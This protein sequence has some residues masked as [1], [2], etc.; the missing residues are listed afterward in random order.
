VEQHDGKWRVTVE[1]EDAAD[2]RDFELGVRTRMGV[3]GK[4]GNVPN[5]LTIQARVVPGASSISNTVVGP[6]S[7][8]IFQFGNVQG[9]VRRHQ[10]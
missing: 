8:D 10:G 4:A 1:F 6:S 2:A 3:V 5:E 7:G 9:E